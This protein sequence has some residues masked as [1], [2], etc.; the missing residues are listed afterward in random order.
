V[1]IRHPFLAFLVPIP[2]LLFPT[3][4]SAQWRYPPAYPGYPAYR[5][6]RE[7]NLRIEVKPK[8]ASV[9][10][11]GY[12]A[13][14]VDEFDGRF[15]RLHVEPGEHDI[16]IYREGYR[17]LR[18]QLYLSADATRTIE[19]TLE[20]L[21]PGDIQDPQPVPSERER[22]EP[23]DEAP[24]M[25][26]GAIPR[27]GR[28]AAPP[29]PPRRAPDEASQYATLSIEVRPGGGTIRIDGER[30]DAPEGNERLI[31]QVTE[32]RHVIEVDRDGYEHF[33][34]EIDAKRGDTTPV[35]INLRRR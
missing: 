10:V 27:R 8:D 33:S 4:A 31:V 32:G 20:Q 14:K 12:F 18:R 9:Y 17:S 23:R 7:S 24:P 34:T 2:A 21:G 25:P 13:G 1:R 16:V 22:V 28:P 15:Q 30:W 19:G 5:Y 26:R 29:E 6:Q 3:I 11:D 35:N